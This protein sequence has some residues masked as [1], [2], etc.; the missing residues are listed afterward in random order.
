[1]TSELPHTPLEWGLLTT[2]VGIIVWVV[3]ALLR[4]TLI[5]RRIHD[6]R[7]KDWEARLV[8]S[9]E[10]SQFWKEAAN[11]RQDALV[12]LTSMIEKLIENDETQSKFYQAFLKVA[13]DKGWGFDDA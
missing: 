7:I 6:E 3:Y 10:N 13:R 12:D 5:S 8:Q 2:C 4:G 9:Q 1:M 11:D